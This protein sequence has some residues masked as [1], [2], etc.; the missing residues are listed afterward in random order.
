MQKI[1][2]FISIFYLFG[3]FVFAQ[4]NVRKK[5]KFSIKTVVI[6]SQQPNSSLKIIKKPKAS[7]PNQEKGTVCVQGTVRLRIT[8]L[9]DGEIGNISL[10]SGL[11]NGANENAVEAAKKIKFRPAIKNGKAISVSKIVEYKFY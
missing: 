8:F 4:Q 7:Y 11:P 2:I 5:Q 6:E 1:I 3:S 9:K 10:V